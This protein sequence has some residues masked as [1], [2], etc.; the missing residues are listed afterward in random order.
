MALDLAGAEELWLTDLATA[1]QQ[2][3]AQH[4]PLLLE[5]TGSDWC[6]WCIKLRNEIFAQPAFID[7]AKKS[8]VLLEVDFPQQKP[9]SDAVKQQNE[10]LQKKYAIEGFP[11]VVVLSPEGKVLGKLGYEEGG[12]A[13]WL[14][15]LQKLTK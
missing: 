10:A 7:Y 12:T 11:T 13:V 9:Q 1:Q 8:L 4:K 6:P 2:A 5:F 15:D 14:R 3:K